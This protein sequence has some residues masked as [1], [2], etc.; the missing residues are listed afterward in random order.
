MDGR[1]RLPSTRMPSWP[2][3]IA[4]RA[5]QSG[6]VEAR[7]GLRMMPTF[8]RPSLSFRTAGFPRYGLEAG[9]WGGTFPRLD[10]LKPAPGIHRL[11]FGL[12]LPFAH[13]ETT[14]VIPHCVGMGARPCAAM[15]VG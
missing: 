13:V 8:P 12:C 10:R 3:G 7:T 9:V 6:R 4:P 5:P 15:E 2:R 14:A 1:P 11:M